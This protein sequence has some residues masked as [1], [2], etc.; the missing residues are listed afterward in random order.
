MLDQIEFSGEMGGDSP[1]V[2]SDVHLISGHC[3]PPA[4]GWRVIAVLPLEQKR[5]WVYCLI[6]ESHRN[7][8]KDPGLLRKVPGL[9]PDGRMVVLVNDDGLDEAGLLEEC[10]LRF[11][12]R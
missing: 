9:D 2:E 4:A 12:R 6:G 1:A 10:G 5:H 7:F 11:R 3:D 8:M